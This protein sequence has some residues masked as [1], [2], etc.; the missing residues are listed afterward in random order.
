MHNAPLQAPIDLLFGILLW[1]VTDCGCDQVML[2]CEVWN[3]DLAGSS[4]VGTGSVDVSQLLNACRGKQQVIAVL[5]DAAGSE[6]RGRV[7]LSLLGVTVDE[8]DVNSVAFTMIS[9]S[10]T[11]T[12]T[13]D[14][15]ADS[16]SEEDASVQWKRMEEHEVGRQPTCCIHAPHC[17]PSWLACAVSE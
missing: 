4:L 7:A 8:S 5:R 16:D 6:V 17:H 12:R 3:K 11:A 10:G 1:L 2:V 15:F 13:V 14:G 9:A